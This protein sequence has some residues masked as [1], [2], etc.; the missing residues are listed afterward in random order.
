M[1]GSR[2]VAKEDQVTVTIQGQLF[3]KAKFT[4]DPATNPKA[5]D[6]AVSGG[7]HAGK[8]QLGIYELNGDKVKFCFSI[9]GQERPTAFTS[10]AN[11]GRTVSVW[12]KEGK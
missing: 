11:D 5:I 12:K 8:T 9:P 10:K 1:K 6:Y 7:P 2:R 4:L 3:M